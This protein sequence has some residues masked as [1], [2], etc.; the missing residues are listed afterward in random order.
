MLAFETSS[1]LL[2][3]NAFRATTA[4][5]T[6]NEFGSTVTVAV[7]SSALISTCVTPCNARSSALTV[8][9]QPPQVMVGQVNLT[10]VAVASGRAS[11]VAGCVEPASVVGDAPLVAVPAEL[12]GCEQPTAIASSKNGMYF[13]IISLKVK[14]DK[15]NNEKVIGKEMESQQNLTATF[16]TK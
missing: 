5:F 11:W 13:N 1:T 12:S 6:S 3:G 15:T 9:R 7:N 2:G 4:F 14:T 8:L 10:S 16:R